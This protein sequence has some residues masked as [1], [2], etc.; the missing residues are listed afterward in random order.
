MQQQNANDEQ[1]ST[2]EKILRL[3][4]EWDRIAENPGAIE[5]TDAQRS[6][7]DARLAAAEA[8]PDD[9]TS[10]EAVVASVRAGR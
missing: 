10:W 3:Q 2:A 7:L 4:D 5:L 8:R 6:E 9:T 1:L